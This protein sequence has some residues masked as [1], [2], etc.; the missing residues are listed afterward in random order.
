MTIVTVFSLL[1][2]ERRSINSFSGCLTVSHFW[3]SG[4]WEETGE[5]FQHLCPLIEWSVNIHPLLCLVSFFYS[6][7][8]IV[9]EF[10][11]PWKWDKTSYFEKKELWFDEILHLIILRFV[12]AYK[13]TTT[14][15]SSS[16]MQRIARFSCITIDFANFLLTTFTNLILQ[17]QLCFEHYRKDN[18]YH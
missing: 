10:Y 18:T 3:L 13:D 2:N 1:S 9:L 12:L 4:N 15:C 11:C 6:I 17:I 5:T 8:F 16:W 14:F 7:N